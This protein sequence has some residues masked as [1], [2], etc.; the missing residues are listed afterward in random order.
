MTEGFWEEITGGGAPGRPPFWRKLIS[1][2]ER[3]GWT[4][5]LRIL[6]CA[7]VGIL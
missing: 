3:W 1:P 4:P 6:R 7:C 2:T 5:K